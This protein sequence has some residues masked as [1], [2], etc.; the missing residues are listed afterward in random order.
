MTLERRV[1][2][3]GGKRTLEQRIVA[4]RPRLSGDK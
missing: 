1:S 2:A 3:L 4:L